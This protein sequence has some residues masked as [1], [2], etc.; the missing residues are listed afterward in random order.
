MQNFVPNV[1]RRKANRSLY[2]GGKKEYRGMG[3]VKLHRRIVSS[4]Q[5]VFTTFPKLVEFANNPPQLPKAH[6]II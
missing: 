6:D 3:F 5:N 2:Q 4:G 1:A